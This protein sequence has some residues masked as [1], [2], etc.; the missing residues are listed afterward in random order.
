MNTQKVLGVI[1]AAYLLVTAYSISTYQPE[2]V[3]VAAPVAV[4]RTPVKAMPVR[5]VVKVNAEQFKCL[6]T[7]IYFESRNQKTDK[8]M[9]AVGY[10]VLNRVAAK[11]YPNSICGVV[12][13]GRKTA[14]GG[15]VRHK[16]QFSWVCD[17]ASDVPS[18]RNKIETRAWIRAQSIAMRVMLGTIKNPVGNSTMYHADYVSPYWKHSYRMVA[19]IEDHIFYDKG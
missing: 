6:A 14:N 4:K 16:C 17:G 5:E 8:A 10:T 9:A 18:N 15:Y 11:S 19:Q 13:Q 7:N 1:V 12:Y 2:P 3:K